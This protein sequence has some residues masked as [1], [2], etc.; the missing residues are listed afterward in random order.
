MV[1]LAIR[2]IAL[3]W[4]AFFA[5]VDPAAAAADEPVT[6]TQAC[7]ASGLVFTLDGS[8]L[9]AD[10]MSDVLLTYSANGG[11]PISRIDLYGL[12]GTPPHAR[13]N[14]SAFEGAARL[15]DM[16]YFITSHA[17][18]EKGK[19]RPNRRRL[20]AV[21]STP[22]GDSEKL[23]P[24]GIAYTALNIDLGKAPQLRSLGLAN[25][26]M[27]LHRQLP[28]LAPGKNGINIEGLA[29]GKNGEL[30]IGLRNPRPQGMTSLIPLENPHSV[31]LGYGEPIFG[32]SYRLDLGGLGISDIALHAEQGVYYILATPHDRDADAKLYRW[33][34]V[35]DDPAVF[36][37]DIDPRDFAAQALAVAPDG[38]RL[39]VL[40]DDGDRLVAVEKKEECKGR[41]RGE[42]QCLCHDLA[43]SARK[44]FRGRWIEL[45]PL[46]LSIP[47]ASP[48]AGSVSAKP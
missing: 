41:L 42:G 11:E 29:A 4:F 9:V 24:V 20:L 1:R 6:F 46:P 14:Y 35:R 37:L 25:S 17:R 23:D 39:M 12:T 45:P 30:L 13:N 19:N 28:H 36:V 5:G 43:D 10:D 22:V 7:D 31:V 26:I 33:S 48:A 16:I 2:S 38:K 18:E 21:K 34:G 3:G 27:Q 47:H 8:L 32:Q 44:Q 15:G 40:S